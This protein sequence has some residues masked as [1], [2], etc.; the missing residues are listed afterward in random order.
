MKNINHI[1]VPV[2]LS[3][4]NKEVAAYAITWAKT[5]GAKITVLYVIPSL[6]QYP[7]YAVLKEVTHKLTDEIAQ[8]M[9]SYVTNNFTDPTIK[10]ESKT[11]N[12]YASEAIVTYAKENNVDLIIMATHERSTLGRFLLGSVTSKVIK[13]S[14]VPVLTVRPQS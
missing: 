14:P 8:S 10:V 9:Q 1:L 3:N 13:I 11:L 7:R 12:G 2:D 4:P 6:D 5:L